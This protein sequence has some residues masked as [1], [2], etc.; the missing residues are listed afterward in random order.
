MIEKV[1]VTGWREACEHA[2]KLLQSIPAGPLAADLVVLSAH[3]YTGHRQWAYGSLV[4]SFLT[5]GTTSLLILQDMPWPTTAPAEAELTAQTWREEGL[6]AEHM[7]SSFGEAR[8]SYDRN[9]Y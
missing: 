5:H 4:T 6:R 8:T 2:A 3:G 9:A 7:I 1:P